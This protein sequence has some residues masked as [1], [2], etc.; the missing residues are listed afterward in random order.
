MSYEFYKFLHYAG[1][2]FLFMAMGGLA[3][4]QLSGG[5]GEKANKLASITHGVALLVILVAGFGLLARIGMQDGI[6][7]WA[8]IK[9]A[10][11][12]VMGAALTLLKRAGST[13]KAMWFALPLLGA[14]AGYIAVTKPGAAA[15]PPPSAEATPN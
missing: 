5:S 10:I 4:H 9:L 13:A 15:S 3:F 7:T 1:V 14:L 8:Y 6:P 12:L 2:L 11:W